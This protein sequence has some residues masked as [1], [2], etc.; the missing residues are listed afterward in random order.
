MSIPK[1]NTKNTADLLN[2]RFLKKNYYKNYK[3]VKIYFLL[4]IPDREDCKI[5]AHRIAATINIF[6]ELNNQVGG[7]VY[8]AEMAIYDSFRLPYH[9]SVYQAEVTSIQKGMMHKINRT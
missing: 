1:M 5:R 2:W 8:S 4:F 6:T 9:S 7:G 3:Y